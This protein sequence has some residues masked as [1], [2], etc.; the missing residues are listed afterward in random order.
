[1]PTAD[2]DNFYLEILR[3]Y[4]DSAN[5]IIFVLCDEM[6]FLLCNRHTEKW[7]G[8]P[9]ADLTRH[10]QR[11]PLT[12]FLVDP[13]A[14]A[15][16]ISNFQETLEGQSRRFECRLH[17]TEP[18]WY[19]FS[20]SKVS[21]AGGAMVVCVARDV[22][23]R[24][25]TGHALT[26]SAAEWT[27][28]MNFMED[29]VYLIDLDDK[30]VRVNE[31][32]YKLT[33]LTPE[34]VIGRDIASIMHP[35]GEKAP[36][37]ICQAR[38][39]RSD[40]YIAME[41]DDPANSTGRP[42]EVMVR[43]MRNEA[44]EP[45]GAVVGVRDL[46]RQRQ[47]EERLRHLA[48]HDILTGLPNRA[49]F[50]D[51]LEHGL[52][53]ARRN[54][55]LLAVLLLN[56]DRFKLVNDTL[57]HNAGD[58]VLQELSGRLR[59]CL[60]DGDTVGRFGGDEFGILIEDIAAMG[61]A[62]MVAH[63]IVDALSHPFVLNGRELYVT[64]SIGISVYPDDAEDSQTLLKNVTAGMYRAKED[65]RNTFR[66]YSADMAA[67][68][69]ERLALES[70]LRHAL[71][72]NEFI[73]HY[74][75]Q[76]D[77]AHD[78]IIGVEALIRWQH[79]ELG[80]VPPNDFISLL[81]E[82]GL[83]VPVGE[84]VLRTACAQSRA[85]QEQGLAPVR[86]AV[87]LSARQFSDPGLITVLRRTLEATNLAADLLELEITESLLM[88]STERTLKTLDELSALGTKLAIDDFGTGYSSLSYL[89]RFPV[90]S[91]KIDRSFIRDVVTDADDHA[92]VSA[93][94]AMAHRLKLRVIAEGVETETQLELLRQ[95]GC[96]AFQG[97]LF[98][99]PVPAREMTELFQRGA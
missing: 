56:L 76:I 52:M 19:E 35:G 46:S 22:T 47:T 26:K 27:Y 64:P 81:E 51:R 34:Q 44:A 69:S 59:S 90:D 8:K 70:G 50:M 40:V 62:A 7:L 83:I 86:M 92:I 16:F 29:A 87:N 94:I 17:G 93:V 18:R 15:L 84:W 25:Q 43:V 89:K 37:P 79:P 5:D 72:R 33:G 54:S 68:A 82:T 85:W 31:A 74:Q 67:K 23:D 24:K 45:V 71:E 66:F 55:R 41:A 1:M 95:H 97:Y 28:A 78:R 49:L 10:K 91:L 65:G 73:L 12:E 80:L 77:L 9:E 99:R 36:C 38:R 96:D 98:S 2:S 42:I 20:L 88:R 32:F 3:A 61:D 11:I 4:F 75:P 53:R 6:K 30:V 57:G 13:D 60:R 63:K 21:I 48:H 14:R 39:A 58:R